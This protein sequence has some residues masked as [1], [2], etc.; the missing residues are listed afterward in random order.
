[1]ER[2]REE[3]MEFL[4]MKRK[5]NNFI[6]EKDDPVKKME[7]IRAERKLIQANNMKKYQD[8]KIALKEE[9]DENEGT[10][11]METMLKER[12][13]WVLEKR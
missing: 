10:D 5:V 9:I 11:I 1:M 8:A 7:Q 13:E 12:R 2:M 6:D 4:G 3:E